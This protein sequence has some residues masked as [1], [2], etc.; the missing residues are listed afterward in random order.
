MTVVL[1]TTTD[2]LML[3]KETKQLSFELM[4][5]VVQGAN[6]CGVSVSEH[7]ARKMIEMT[8]TMTPYA[9]SMKLDY[10]HCREMEIEYIYSRPI[11][12]ALQAGYDMKKVSMLEKQLRFIQEGY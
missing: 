3:C 12:T 4:L 11:Q 1:N 5:E 8:E 7:F 10:D 6:H 2:R 9:P